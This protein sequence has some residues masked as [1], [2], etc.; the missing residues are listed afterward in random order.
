MWSAEWR[1]RRRRARLARACRRRSKL[2]ARFRAVHRLR[3][4]D[5]DFGGTRD[6]VDAGFAGDQFFRGG[7][8][9]VTRP[10]NA[11]DARHSFRSEGQSR[12]GLRAAHLKEVRD[13]E[14]GRE[15][16]N[17]GAGPR[18]GDADGLDAGDLRG[19]HVHQQRGGQGISAGGRVCAHGIERA[20]DLAETAAVGII[21]EAFLRQLETGVLA[22]VRGGG[23]DRALEFGRERARAGV[24]RTDAPSKPSN[25][26][27]YSSRAASPRRRTSSRIGRDD[28]LGFVEALRLAG[29]QRARRL[30]SPGFES[31]HY[32]LVQRI[33][34][35][36]LRSGFLQARNDGAHGGFRQGWC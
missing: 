19:N 30:C 24:M 14:P 13:A 16:E 28:A 4:D 7:D 1:R 8:I 17:L 23:E 15:A 10:N 32:D 31:L 6:E 29:E 18:A 25:L 26:R 21:D 27:A 5:D 34:D 36:A 35:D 22:N 33:F 9:N 3:G 2:E 12:D 20:H 11:I